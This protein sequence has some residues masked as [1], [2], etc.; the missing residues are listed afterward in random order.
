MKNK[1]ENSE[2]ISVII[3][4]YNCSHF[5]SRAIDSILSQTYD[6]YDLII[7][8]DGSTDNSLQVCKQYAAKNN[9]IRI[10]TQD[11]AGVASARNRGLKEVIGKYVFFLDSDDYLRDDCLELL[12]ESRNSTGAQW[13]I[14]N[15][16][17]IDTNGKIL[18]DHVPLVIN[19]IAS[20]KSKILYENENAN[21]YLLSYIYSPEG[22]QLIT[23]S[24]NKLYL[25]DIINKYNI[26]FPTNMKYSEDIIFNLKY[27]RYIKKTLIINQPLLSYTVSN[28]GLSFSAIIA[29]ELLSIEN[30]IYEEFVK[31][32]SDIDKLSSNEIE[33]LCSCFFVYHIISA[34]IRGSICRQNKLEQYNEIKKIVKDRTFRKRLKYYSRK[35]G[36]SIMI[37]FMLKIKAAKLVMYFCKLKALKRFNVQ[38]Q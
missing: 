34:L 10:F 5:I 36:Q 4:V 30:R 27:M 25:F 8:D 23:A 2:I 33:R 12:Y 15:I 20:D 11:N 16:S 3:P 24:W 6:N 37:P 14:G 19:G 17:E 13:V 38:H 31:T 7:V 32:L 29:N 9:R 26:T 18:R 22:A 1:R 28:D 21:G 35:N